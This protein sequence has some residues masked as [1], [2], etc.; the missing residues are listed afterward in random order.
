MI[1]SSDTSEVKILLIG[2]GSIARRHIANLR[3]VDPGCR[4]AVLRRAASGIAEGADETFFSTEQA[5]AWKPDAVIVANPAPFHVAGARPFAEQ[6]IPLLVEKPISDSLGGVAEFITT[7]AAH[8]AP[9]LVGYTL[10]FNAALRALKTSLDRGDIGRALSLVAQVGQYL[11]DWRPGSDFGKTVTA[12]RELGGG[13]LL[14]LS[15]EL[16]CARWLMGEV[17]AVS[18]VTAQLGGLGL[19]VEDVA[20]ITME[21]ASGALGH[22]HLDMVQRCPTRTCRVMGTDGTLEWDALAGAVRRFDPASKRWSDVALPVQDRN[23]MYVDEM[24]HFLDCVRGKASPL[25]TG[26][27][28]LAALQIALA[29]RRSAETGSKVTL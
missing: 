22:V 24:K 25:V 7:C 14:E 13:V 1:Q 3:D 6:G 27:D 26:E 8:R 9:L 28:G 17:A 16:D 4:V 5:I 15:H 23:A 11:P 10:R 19:D 18:A 2:Y 21:F 12:R 20:E 29:A